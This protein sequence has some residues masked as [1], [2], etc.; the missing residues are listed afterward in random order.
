INLSS[1]IKP[2]PL[3]VKPSGN[4]FFLEISP[5]QRYKQK[6]TEKRKKQLGY[7][8]SFPDDLI[9][10]ILSYVNSP[11]D[12]LTLS[13]VSKIIYC[14]CSNEELWKN[15]YLKYYNS[16]ESFQQKFEKNGWKGSWRSSLLNFP[17]D[18]HKRDQITKFLKCEY[19]LLCSDT[20][21][22][23]YQCSQ[24]NYHLIFEKVIAIESLFQNKSSSDV[25]R[26]TTIDIPYNQVSRISE[27][28]MTLENFANNWT[29]YPF[30]LV[31]PNDTDRKRWP[32][33]E[34][35][36]LLKRFPN[37]RFRQESVKWPLDFYSD[38]YRKNEDESPL[39]LFDCNSDAM[40]T[41]TKEYE[42]PDCFKYDLFQLFNKDDIKCRPDYRWIIIGCKRTGSTFHKDPNSTSAW[43]TVISGCKLWVMLPPNVI[44]PGVS[45]SEDQSEVTSPISLAEWV[46]SG[47]FNDILGMSNV[48]ENN[49]LVCITFPGECIYVPAGWWHCVIN[50]KDS[51][52]LTQNFIPKKGLVN[53][54][55]F[56]KNKKKQISGFHFKDVN[57]SI[58]SVIKK[59]KNQNNRRIEIFRDYL[60]KFQEI[61]EKYGIDETEDCGE[62]YGIIPIPLLELFEELLIQDNNSKLL[63]ETKE[64][65]RQLEKERYNE[66]NLKVKSSKLWDELIHGRIEN[67]EIQEKDNDNQ[68]SNGFTFNFDESDDD[69]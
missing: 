60:K 24:I 26:K 66:G 38:Y 16:D 34:M 19:N 69:E 12:L 39:Y 36:D 52:A 55:D 50:L 3:N 37:E 47:F 57:R 49:C 44:P 33:W 10:K 8:V 7:L 20:I 67:K 18:T 56:F 54:F 29:N 28:E 53:V 46:L 22:R 5:D 62:Q 25:N 31:N 48:K 61:K 64:E 65:L 14:Y 21:F 42:V 13:H 17:S 45:V 11:K 2:H 51:I 4:K 6:I 59:N 63:N 68:V 9:F 35:T 58:K 23:P 41:I 30:I 40:K 15:I 32:Q 43:N 27:N 1:S